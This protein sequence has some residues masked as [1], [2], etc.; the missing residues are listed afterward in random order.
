MNSFAK[1]IAPHR[2][3]FRRVHEYA[4]GKKVEL[5]VVGGFLRDIYLNRSKQDPDIDFCMARGAIAFVKGLARNLKFGFVDL[6]EL[7]GCCRL[8]VRSPGSTCTVDIADF[9]GATLAEDLALRDFSVNTVCLALSDLVGGDDP[10]LSII[11][12]YG[13]RRD[14]KHKRLR[15][16]Y[17]KVFD[18]DPLRV[19]RA[20][21][22]SA[23]FGFAIGEEVSAAIGRKKRLLAKVSG[24]RIR[25]EL[26]KILESGRAY[27]CLCA[28]DEQDILGL[29]FP[30]I[31]AMKRVKRAGK[32]RL[33]V[34]KHTSDTVRHIERLCGRMM[35]NADIASYLRT[36]VSGSRSM[37]ALIKLAAILH[38]VGKPRTFKYKQGKI[39]FYGHERLGS[40]MA[41]D[42][43]RRL[44]LSNEEERMISRIT[45][46]HLRPGYMATMPAVTPRAIFRFFR[47]AGTGSVAILLL[48]LADERA[49]SGYAVVEK[50]RPRYERLIFRLIRMYFDKQVAH[51]Q[52]RFL[53]GHDIMQLGSLP[54]SAAVGAIL[55]E[56][57][58]LQAIKTITTRVQALT[59][60]ARLIKE[61]KSDHK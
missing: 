1:S 13:A 51:P 35:R 46:L 19:L 39:S 43:A 32:D 60:A 45:F 44:K 30:E 38:D 4:L 37:Y 16:L 12:L 47:D 6:D 57:E 24:E 61:A 31:R 15:I 55:R 10:S 22:L 11:D 20:F 23:V 48:A 58:E 5:Y 50:I 40:R 18:D 9:R 7:H 53:T 26:F 59:Y 25:D 52:K 29:L 34:W 36:P 54:P 8:V 33:D 28:L 49:T 2:A 41:S 27:E 56:L 21:S 42:I 3:L 17:A 14:M